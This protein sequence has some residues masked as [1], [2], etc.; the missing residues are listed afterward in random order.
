MWETYRRSKC[1]SILRRCGS[2]FQ[3]PH[4]NKREQRD[5]TQMQACSEKLRSKY[6]VGVCFPLVLKHSFDKHAIK[7]SEIVTRARGLRDEIKQC[8]LGPRHSTVRDANCSFKWDSKRAHYNALEFRRI[9][10]INARSTRQEF[11]CKIETFRL[12]RCWLMQR[13]NCRR[14]PRRLLTTSFQYRGPQLGG[15]PFTRS[16]D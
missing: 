2:V 6:N 8:C 14:A 3:E 11:T 16:L 10:E 9:D 15:C 1:T 13:M 4:A 5:D 12:C 7:N